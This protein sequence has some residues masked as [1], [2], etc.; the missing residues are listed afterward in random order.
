M[1]ERHDAVPDV[2]A[3]DLDRRIAQRQLRVAEEAEVTLDEIATWE[4]ELAQGGWCVRA[5]AGHRNEV[6]RRGDPAD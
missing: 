4:R 1:A 5:D 2:A 6:C 3:H